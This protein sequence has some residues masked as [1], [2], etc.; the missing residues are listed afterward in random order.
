MWE[1]CGDIHHVEKCGDI[2]GPYK[3]HIKGLKLYVLI[4]YDDVI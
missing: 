1:K 2:I 3:I 4:I